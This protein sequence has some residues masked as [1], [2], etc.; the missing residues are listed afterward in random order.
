[1]NHC[2]SSINFGPYLKNFD[3]IYHENLDK[4]MIGRAIY[5]DV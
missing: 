1:M 4:E 5:E 2:F 3:I